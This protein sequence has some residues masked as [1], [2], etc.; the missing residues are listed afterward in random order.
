MSKAKQKDSIAIFPNHGRVS[1]R[2]GRATV[3]GGPQRGKG[4]NRTDT[5]RPQMFKGI[6]AAM[7]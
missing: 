4:G 6:K 5:K 2:E 7:T 1:H 3:R